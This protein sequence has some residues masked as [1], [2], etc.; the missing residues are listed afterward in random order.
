MVFRRIFSPHGVR[1]KAV[2]LLGEIDDAA[3]RAVT[4]PLTRQ[5]VSLWMGFL[6][7]FLKFFLGQIIIIFLRFWHLVIR[8]YYYR[9]TKS[10]SPKP[11][12]IFLRFVIIRIKY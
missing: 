2:S 1:K 4:E 3:L 11:D 6:F 9:W 12:Y 10:R 5:L 7:K 8:V